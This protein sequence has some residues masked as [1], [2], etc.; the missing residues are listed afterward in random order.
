MQYL[1]RTFSVG[2]GGEGRLMLKCSAVQLW[3]INICFCTNKMW[4]IL[5]W[6]QH[7]SF[8]YFCS[9]GLP[10][11]CMAR[12]VMI[13]IRVISIT[14]AIWRGGPWNR[15]FIGSWN[16]NEQSEWNLGQNRTFLGPNGTRCAGYHFRPP[17]N[18]PRNGYCPPQNHYVPPHKKQVH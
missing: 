16:G 3:S 1:I 13:L 7:I 9:L 11:V 2:G 15:D 10:D 17:Y 5:N 4:R 6:I 18:G 14:R 8:I 12:D